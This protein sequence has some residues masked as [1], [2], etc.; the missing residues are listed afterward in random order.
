MKTKF[1]EFLGMFAL[2]LQTAVAVPAVAGEQ[3]HYVQSD[4][5][6]GFSGDFQNFCQQH[7]RQAKQKYLKLKGCKS[8]RENGVQLRYEPDSACLCESIEGADLS[9]GQPDLRCTFGIH[10]S[11]ETND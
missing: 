6:L 1:I 11:C 4:P 9:Q 2:I 7:Q 10:W 3:S 5:S 8:K